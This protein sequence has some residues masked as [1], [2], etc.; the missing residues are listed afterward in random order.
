[1]LTTS[2][3]GRRVLP[4]LGPEGV[5]ALVTRFEEGQRQ[6]VD[7]EEF[8]VSDKM[9]AVVQREEGDYAELLEAFDKTR[10]ESKVQQMVLNRGKH[11]EVIFE[12]KLQQPSTLELEAEEA[13]EDEAN[14]VMGPIKRSRVMNHST[15]DGCI[16]IQIPVSQI[17]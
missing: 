1:M 6:L 5:Q 13:K 7:D 4:I 10:T 11:D 12:R 9:W 3:E 16:K 8:P 14:P 15:N 17:L 2:D